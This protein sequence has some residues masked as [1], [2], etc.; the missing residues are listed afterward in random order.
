M[1]EKLPLIKK[2]SDEIKNIMVKNVESLLDRGEKLESLDSKTHELC[3]SSN[4]FYRSG[5]DLKC[6]MLREKMCASFAILMVILI[7]LAATVFV[8]YGI[9]KHL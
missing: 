8:I 1:T 6:Q 7:C 2:E 4:N 5:K 3:E 9:S